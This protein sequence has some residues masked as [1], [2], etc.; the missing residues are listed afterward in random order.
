M[1]LRP[2]SYSVQLARKSLNEYLRPGRWQPV[3]EWLG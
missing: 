3:P 1:L 2:L